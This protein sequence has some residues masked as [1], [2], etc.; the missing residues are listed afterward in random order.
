MSKAFLFLITALV[1]SCSCF[2]NLIK[3][4]KKNNVFLKKELK[5]KHLITLR[6]NFFKNVKNNINSYTNKSIYMP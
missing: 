4:E 2:I 1:M 3:K 6:L 5:L